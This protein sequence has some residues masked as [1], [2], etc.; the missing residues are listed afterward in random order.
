VDLRGSVVDMV[1]RYNIINS[2]G[3]Q[4]LGIGT[5]FVQGV[6]KRETEQK[7]RKNQE[8]DVSVRKANENLIQLLLLI[9]VKY[10][11]SSDDHSDQ[12]KLRFCH[13]EEDRCKRGRKEDTDLQTL[14]AMRKSTGNA[15][16]VWYNETI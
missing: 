10:F 7:I 2:S 9:L 1:Q 3:V 8:I 11:T 5:G 12:R 16:S 4:R 14:S 15:Q 13:G 6:V